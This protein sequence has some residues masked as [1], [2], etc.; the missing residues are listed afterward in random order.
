[1]RS[2]PRRRRRSRRTAASSSCPDPSDRLEPVRVVRTT[3]TT[4]GGRRQET[5]EIEILSAEWTWVTT[6]PASRAP[7]ATVVGIGHHRSDIENHGLNEG[8]RDWHFDHVY[9]HDPVAMRVLTLL[10]APAGTS[11]RRSSA[12][13]GSR[14]CVCGTR[15]VPSSSSS[16]QR[17]APRRP[18]SRRGEPGPLRSQSRASVAPRSPSPH[19]AQGVPRARRRGPPHAGEPCAKLPRRG[20]VPRA[21]RELTLAGRLRN[22]CTTRRVLTSPARGRYPGVPPR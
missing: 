3:E 2:L 11:W 9:R 22:R 16:P 21:R 7:T 20:F 12:G 14:P 13:P 1:M 4:D 10:T 8:A 18:T 6:L 5:G 19:R 15:S 17:S